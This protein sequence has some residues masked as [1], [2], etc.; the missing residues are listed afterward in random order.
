M[1]AIRFADASFLRP[2]NHLICQD[3]KSVGLHPGRSCRNEHTGGEHVRTN[4]LFARLRW[5]PRESTR[6]VACVE[7]PVN[8]RL[9]RFAKTSAYRIEASLACAMLCCPASPRT[10]NAP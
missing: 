1:S 3:D 7:V 6:F 8:F 4:S 5:S 10:T 9:P 2:L